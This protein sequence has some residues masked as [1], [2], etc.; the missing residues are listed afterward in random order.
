ML[1]V[2]QGR[3]AAAQTRWLA[4]H[5]P[6]CRWQ[7]WGVPDQAVLFTCLEHAPNSFDAERLHGY[8][9]TT[10]TYSVHW[11]VMEANR[12]RTGKGPAHR[13][14]GSSFRIR[15]GTG[16]TSGNLTSATAWPAD[17][18]HQ[19]PCRALL[20]EV[21]A[22]RVTSA[23]VAT[24]DRDITSQPPPACAALLPGGGMLPCPVGSCA[25][26]SLLCL[27][28]SPGATGPTD[29][30]P[31]QWRK[32]KAVGAGVVRCNFKWRPGLACP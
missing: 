6:C 11:V 15:N 27:C 5:L 29:E 17:R 14:L 19:V 26:K 8:V 7:Y 22:A 13:W 1:R 25:R 23:F 10:R 2:V 21:T 31:N 24:C 16:C 20:A 18:L 4:L 3:C 30:T 28:D 12:L 32:N 9:Q